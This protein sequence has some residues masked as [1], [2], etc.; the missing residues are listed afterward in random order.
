MNSLDA[1]V[2]Q[3]LP[4]AER[5]MLAGV[6]PRRAA[7]N[8]ASAAVDGLSGLGYIYRDAAG[9]T[10]SMPGPDPYDRSYKPT[11]SPPP[12]YAPPPPV[13][14]KPAVPAPPP[15][16]SPKPVV[17]APGQIHI[18]PWP[19]TAP[20]PVKI[21]MPVTV[22]APTSSSAPSSP[23]IE[24]I[25]GPELPSKFQPGGE[26]APVAAPA[27]AAAPSAAGASIAA[28]VVGALML[29]GGKKK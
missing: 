15:P 18:L 1:L 6:S 5:Q 13:S 23:R 20:T 29:F 16:V 3:A 7:R 25:V 28:L 14:P 8:A 17:P 21:T 19:G 9:Q 10:I 11:P 27:A 12:Q 4:L 24:D 22:K 26:A 2:Q